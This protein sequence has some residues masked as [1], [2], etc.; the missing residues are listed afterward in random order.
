MRAI[1]AMFQWKY[2]IIYVPLL[3]GT[4]L[5]VVFGAATL[6]DFDA[7]FYLGDLLFATCAAWVIGHWWTSPSLGKKWRQASRAERRANRLPSQSRFYLWAVGV[8]ACYLAILA[9]SIVMTHRIFRAKDLAR[10]S[11]FLIPANDRNPPHWGC[12]ER[13]LTVFFGNSIAA[14][15]RRFPFK[16][17]TADGKPF[18][19][20][21][22]DAQGNILLSAEILDRDGRV[23][24]RITKGRFQINPNNI[25][26]RERPDRSTLIL[27]DQYGREI[28]VRYL[29]PR[30]VKL[31]GTVYLSSD[32][33]ILINDDAVELLFA[34][35]KPSEGVKL[36][37]QC[38][39][40]VGLY[41]EGGNWGFK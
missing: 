19:V 11:G 26:S 3:F 20:I 35:R 29:N 22:Q 13:P 7:L 12:A 31:T 38:L 9:T 21:D 33:R 5:A 4:A 32:V 17:I 34:D 41:V 36:F 28:S 8:T 1:R 37:E 27:H 40:D 10:L 24:A 18:V 14:T 23:I 39:G 15:A 6:E 16:A 30:A 25:L 2:T